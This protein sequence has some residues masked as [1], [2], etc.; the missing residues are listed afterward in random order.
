MQHNIDILH[1]VVTDGRARKQAIASGRPVEDRKD[2]WREGLQPRN[3]V[4]ARTVPVLEKEGERLRRELARM[5]AENM[6]L[7]K[8]LR[9]TVR[10]REEADRVCEEIFAFLEDVSFSFVFFLDLLGNFLN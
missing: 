2:L 7:E 5:E 4:R 9:A 8:Q 6:K 10:E 3:V 1:K